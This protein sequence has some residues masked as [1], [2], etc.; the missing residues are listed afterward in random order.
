MY[1]GFF[2]TSL[3]EVVI[4]KEFLSEKMVQIISKP[5]M[6]LKLMTG[7]Q[8]G[9]HMLQKNR[10]KTLPPEIFFDLHLCAYLDIRRTQFSCC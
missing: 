1:K 9:L 6:D 3:E 4:L 2:F 5:F 10:E 8:T 7:S